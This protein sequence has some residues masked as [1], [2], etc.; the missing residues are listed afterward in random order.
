MAAA[1]LDWD[2]LKYFLA[3][4][5]T[6]STLG[7]GRM[8]KVSQTT[9]A[10]RI[11]AFESKLGLVL[12]ERR[13]A[14]YTLTPGGEALVAQAEATETAAG[15]FAEA[16][17]AQARDATGTVCVSAL[18]LYTATILP[19]LMKDLHDV[20]PGLRIELDAAEL[21]RDLIAGEADIAL[22]AVRRTLFD[23]S[24]V[25]RRIAPD[26]WTLYCSR[27]YAA[28]HARPRT[29]ADLRTHPIVGGGGE[30]VWPMYRAWLQRHRLEEAVTIHHNSAI[31]LLAAVR[32]GAGLAVL[33]S[34][35]ADRDPDLV[36]CLEPM[37]GD[38][39]EL[40]LLTSER[41]RH[42]PRVRAVMDFLGERLTRMARV[43]PA[44]DDDAWAA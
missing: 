33:P 30:K 7:A 10:R 40:W 18:E 5:R 8:L 37:H 16:A 3:I 20:H 21:P 23:G 11:A 36:R 43:A 38:D 41:L 19:P 27:A 29:A 14:G 28:A 39:V 31:G 2:D 32:A 15:A 4:A 34:F 26:P 13:Q 42:T 9:V 35:V 24:L 22:R 6:G 17:S 12:F 44:D 25:G 1:S